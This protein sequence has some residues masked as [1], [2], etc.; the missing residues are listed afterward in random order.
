MIENLLTIALVPQSLV[1]FFVKESDNQVYYLI[2]VINPISGSVR[3]NDLSIL[4][5]HE[6]HV[7]VT[8]VERSDTD[9]HFIYKDTESPPVN[10]LI[11]TSPV[12]H[13]RGKV[14]GCAAKTHWQF[15]LPDH[16]SETIIDNLKVAIWINEDILKFQVTM[17]DALLVKVSNGHCDLGSVELD[18][19]F[20]ESLLFLEHLIKFTSLDEGHDEI[21]TE[22]GLE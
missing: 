16:F 6:Q 12:D 3:E 11:V 4:N 17:C 9:K 19:L 8:V 2:W 22:L 18:N 7:S 14:L 13:L 20:S 10:I 1:L 21:E 15:F 5:F